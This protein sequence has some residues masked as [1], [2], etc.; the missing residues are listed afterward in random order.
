MKRLLD[1]EETCA[2]LQK[3]IIR[4]EIFRIDTIDSQKLQRL[5]QT[6]DRIIELILNV[7]NSNMMIDSIISTA[8]HLWSTKELFSLHVCGSMSD[9]AIKNL[10]EWVINHSNL[11][12]EHSFATIYQANWFSLW[13]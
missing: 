9:D 13:W 1:D 2:L 12:K 5:A 6:F 7:K 10:R 4:L 11:T 8:I 3:R